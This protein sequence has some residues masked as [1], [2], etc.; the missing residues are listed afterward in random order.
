MMERFEDIMTKKEI[1]VKHNDVKEENKDERFG[2]FIVLQDK[3][4]KLQKRKVELAAASEDTKIFSMKMSGLDPNAV[5][6]IQ[7]CHDVILKCLTRNLSR[8]MKNFAR[9]SS[10]GPHNEK[11]CKAR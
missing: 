5:K 9:P 3:M 8:T 2:K 10:L 1:C 7:F 11:L 4:I 6:I